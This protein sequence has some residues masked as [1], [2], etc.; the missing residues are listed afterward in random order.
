MQS[1]PGLVIL[2]GSIVK[3]KWAVN[4][5]FMALYAFAAVLI[6][7]VGWGYQM[8]FGDKFIPFLGQPDVALDQKFLLRRTFVGY[9]PNATMVYFQFVFAAITLIL[10]AGALLGRMNFHAWM[11][12]VPL[13][14]TFSYTI[15][16]YSIWCP[17]GWLYKKGIID[18]SGG[19]IPWYTMM[20]LHKKISFLKHVDDTMAIFHTHAIAGSLGGILTGIF[21]EPKLCRIFYLVPEWE[22]YIGL[23]NGFHNNRAGAGFKQLGVQ[24]LGILFVVF[25]NVIMT[26]IICVVIKFV[27]PLRLSEEQLSTGDD[28]IHGEEAYALWGDGEKYQSRHNSFYTADQEIPQSTKSAGAGGQVEMA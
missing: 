20:V 3:K 15:T 4:S 7:W 2:Y 9:L 6:C 21:A 28:A 16:A 26:S 12:F 18:Y 27:V 10:I 24:L 13:W 11:I 5:A 1:V 17:T 22:H 19:S 8:A 23:L 25:T 14:L